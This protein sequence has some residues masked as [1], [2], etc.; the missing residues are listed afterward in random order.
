MTIGYGI[1]LVLAL[2]LLFTYF[3]LIKQRE[4]WLGILFICVS[5]VN[6]GYF[7]LSVA[8][9]L[10]IAILG[11]NV[12]YLGSIFLSV[13]MLLTI[14]RLC[15]FSIRAW[16]VILCLSLAAVMFCLVLTSGFLPWYYQELALD[17]SGTS[18]KLIKTY[19]P[20]HFTYLIY[21]FGYF[22]AMIASIILSV[23]QK[24]MGSFKLAVLLAGV[25]CGNIL[26]WLF[27][28]FIHFEFE[29]LSVTYIF[30]EIILLALYWMMQDYVHVD[31]LNQIIS[32]TQPQKYSDLSQMSPEE[33]M[34]RALALLSN[35][36]LLA[37]REREVLELVLQ[38]QKRKDIAKQLHVS[39]NTVKTHTRNLYA[40][41]GVANREELY[42]RVL[43]L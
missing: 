24:R 41:L 27:E 34:T 16:H 10:P 18:S 35:G 39:E 25:V 32:H 42:T 15:G 33:K 20:L 28:K 2:G 31:E 21:L 23:C 22:S 36:E 12:A 30:S 13:C 11:N 14:V 29:I 17:T 43:N 9:N 5:I 40:K 4:F 1:S 19:G 7:V 8:P 26:V 6:L 3:L 38:N 37:T